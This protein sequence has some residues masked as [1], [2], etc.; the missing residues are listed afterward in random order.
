MQGKKGGGGG[1]CVF[2]KKDHEF[3]NKFEKEAPTTGPP[4]SGTY[5]RRGPVGATAAAATVGQD[6]LD[7][8][9]PW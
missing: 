6:R 7:T 1:K 8:P 4:F 3:S 5:L 9:V 2:L